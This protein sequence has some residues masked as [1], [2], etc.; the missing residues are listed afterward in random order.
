MFVLVLTCMGQTESP[1]TQVG[2]SVGNATKTVFNGVDG[3]V[4][5]Y[6]P[7]VKLQ[8]EREVHIIWNERYY[9]GSPMEN[10]TMGISDKEATVE[11]Q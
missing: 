1:E 3:L 9:T 4:D 10:E 8:T 2:G 11:T 7:K 6:V 5:R